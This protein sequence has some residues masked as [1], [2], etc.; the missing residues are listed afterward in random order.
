MADDGLERLKKRL[1]K[2][3]EV[4]GGR[5]QEPELPY[6]P[7]KA[8]S[9]WREP[10]EPQEILSEVLKEPRFKNMKI[11]IWALILLVLGLVVAASLYLFGGFGAIS[12]RNIDITIS[13][14][15]EVAGGDLVR[16]E[17][18]IHNKNKVKLALADLSFKYPD[19]SRPVNKLPTQ[20]LIER[21][22][23]GEVESGG[24]VKQ[25]FAAYV[26]GPENFE[27]EAEATLE[28]RAEG[29]N[30]I[31]EKSQNQIVKIIRSPVGVSIAAPQ[32]I[33][34]GREVSFKINYVSNSSDA[35][36][37][38]ALNVIYPDGFTFKNASPRPSEG[39]SRWI[40]GDLAAGA[41]GA[42]TISGIF[43][44]ED[45]S[46]K[47]ISAQVG[48]LDGQNLSVYG[49]ATNSLV[50]RRMFIDL[51]AKINGEDEGNAVKTGDL[52]SVEI[53][54]KNNLLQ[55]VRDASIEVNLEGQAIDE[56]SISVF[57]GS[58]RGFDKKVV[59]SPSSLKD[60]VL[61]D[62]GEEGRIGFGFRVLDA[63]SLSRKGLKNAVIKLTGEIKPGVAPEGFGG[64]DVSGRFEIELKIET[65]LQLSSQGFYYSS[66]LGGSGPLPPRVGKETVYTVIW[67][68]ANLSNDVS[69]VR[70]KASLPAYV[71]WKGV[72]KPADE[73]LIYDAVRSEIVWRPGNVKAGVGIT[74]PA[75]EAAFQL[76]L[77]AS[78]SQIGSSPVLLFDILAEG[79]DDFTGNTLNDALPALTTDILRSDSQTKSGDG[80]V[81][82]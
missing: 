16:W 72:V 19:G 53:A 47:N 37:N 8:S 52:V 24:V 26:F 21:V 48:V 70:V 68:L 32:E 43:E 36:R 17:V 30:A 50:I 27:G 79:R 5:F 74:Q 51:V 29:S 33:N 78:A 54:W 41:S 66:I 34:S 73:S 18:S 71:R 38:L 15:Q 2:K 3:G 12:A 9:S 55:A 65:D 40:L 46:Q 11:F 42:V 14:P 13:V 82:E 77:I 31:F 44:G 60:L 62:P 69:G 45:S 35:I 25:I 64:A 58:Y 28:Y 59:W 81:T 4:F 57:S 39:Q 20:F 49:A 22:S 6:R 10:Q 75:R 76:G 67:T 56:R 63:L 23:V 1:Y 61:L 7:E 80:V